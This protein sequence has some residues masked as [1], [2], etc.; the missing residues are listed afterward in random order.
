V[1]V[2][3]PGTEAVRDQLRQPGRGE[4]HHAGVQ[5]GVQR[6]LVNVRCFAVVGH[7]PGAAVRVDQQRVHQVG[8]LVRLGTEHRLEPSCP[9]AEQADGGRA[10]DRL[11]HRVRGKQFC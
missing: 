2:V 6:G 11:V 5:R 4:R 10:G 1:T 7:Q 3:E 9:F 8:L